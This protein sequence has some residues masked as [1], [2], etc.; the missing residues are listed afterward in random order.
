LTVEF[1]L[2]VTWGPD[3]ESKADAEKDT[4]LFRSPALVNLG[5]DTWKNRN[6]Y[7]LGKDGIRLKAREVFKGQWQERAILNDACW[8]WVGTQ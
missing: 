7:L 6:V 8:D 1:N 4:E 5:A 2:G 3:R